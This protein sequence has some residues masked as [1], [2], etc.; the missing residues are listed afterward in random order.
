MNADLNVLRA[1][2]CAVE[3]ARERIFSAARELFYRQGIK[4]VGVEAIAAEAGTTK[5]TLYRHYSSKDQLVAEILKAHD[6]EFWEWWEG[7]TVPLNG[8][9]RRQ[10][11]RLF[12]EFEEL[13]C[14]EGSCR[15]CPIA[16]AAV[17]IVDDEHPARQIVKHHHDELRRRLRLLCEQMG[18]QAPDRLSDALFLLMSGSFLARLVFDNAGPINS[19]YEAAQVLLDSPLGV[20]AG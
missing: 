14:D 19:V 5:M 3:C 13:A 12:R 16:N 7:I 6:K 4:A 17:E 2:D 10:I 9:P 1:D 15:G 8:Q 20:P 18:A 11:E